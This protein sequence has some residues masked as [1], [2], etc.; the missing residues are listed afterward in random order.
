MQ[1]STTVPQETVD[2]IVA[3]GDSICKPHEA[4][5]ALRSRA[6]IQPNVKGE[7]TVKLTER[8]IRH[9]VCGEGRHHGEPDVARLR[10]LP[11]AIKAVRQSD[12]YHHELNQQPILRS[13]G[14][15]LPEKSQTVYER[16]SGMGKSKTFAYTDSGVLTGWQLN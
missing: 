16:R 3:G 2:A 15:K 10:S 6:T 4:I 5:A 1:Q 13:P 14:E 8:P 12:S 9:Y 7:E 11:L